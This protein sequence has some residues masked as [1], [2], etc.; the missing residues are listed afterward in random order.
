MRFQLFGPFFP[1]VYSQG[2]FR[3]EVVDSVPPHSRL[4]CIRPVEYPLESLFLTV[5]P[6]L[7]PLRNPQ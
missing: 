6:I 7:I 4:S 5:G 3:L 2:T 1:L